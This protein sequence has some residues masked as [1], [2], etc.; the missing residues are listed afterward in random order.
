MP[1]QSE[2]VASLPGDRPKVV[3]GGRVRDFDQAVVRV[4][5]GPRAQ[6][7]QGRQ[8]GNVW[9]SAVPHGGTEKVEVI[10]VASGNRGR[11][12]LAPVICSLD[13]VSDP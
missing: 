7:P 11:A 10:A 2:Q 9:H 8:L 1:G 3:E 4:T 13:N 12:M 5:C 6:S